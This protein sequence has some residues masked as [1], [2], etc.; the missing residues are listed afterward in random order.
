[1]HRI[2]LV[3]AVLAVGL[4]VPATAIAAS[5]PS[6]TTGNATAITTNSAVLNGTVNPNGSKTTYDFQ[7]GPT[8]ALGS[9]TKATSAGS[10]TKAASVKSALSGLTPGS[11]YYFR[12]V[13]ANSSGGT[14]TGAILSFRT[15]GNPPPGAS[16]GGA[17]N[18]GKTSVTLTGIV[19]P[20]KQTTNW[21][22]QYGETTSYGVQTFGGTVAAG[23]A[24]VAVSEQIVGL[25]PGTTFHYR[26]VA[27]HGTEDLGAGADATFETLPS[28][29]PKPQ[30]TASTTHRGSNKVPV[31]F[32][33]SGHVRGPSSTPA[34]LECVGMVR[35]SYFLGRRSIHTVT[36]QLQPGCS[37]AA[38][39]TFRRLPGRGPRGRT[40]KLTVKVRFLGNGYLAAASARNRTI[41]LR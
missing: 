32:T 5:S 13:A 22:F 26:L 38:T 7:W 37:F 9:E 18:V 24:P 28:P 3:T 20:Q 11:T 8:T 19:Y 25:A 41:T 12:I 36:T 10:G 31:T 2:K 40:V 6:V 23:T 39:S 21:V 30:V 4:A 29:A 35:V 34:S 1:M 14:G 27:L 17:E 16:T 33:T 15:A